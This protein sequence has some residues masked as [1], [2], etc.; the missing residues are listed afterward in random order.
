M[1]LLFAPSLP[2][3]TCLSSHGPALVAPPVC[4]GSPSRTLPAGGR[5]RFLKPR[6]SRWPRPV[7]GRRGWRAPPT[8]GV[9]LQQK[10][11]GPSGPSP[12]VPRSPGPSGRISREGVWQQAQGRARPTSGSCEEG[13]GARRTGG[14]PSTSRPSGHEAWSEGAAVPRGPLE[15]CVL[16]PGLHPTAQHRAA[17]VGLWEGAVSSRVRRR[18]GLSLI[19]SR[20]PPVPGCGRPAGPAAPAPAAGTNAA[21]SPQGWG[22]RRRPCCRPSGATSAPSSGAG[23]AASTSRRWPR[24]PWPP[25]RPRTRPCSGSGG[26]TTW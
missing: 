12:S 15:S 10:G 16:V 25:W 4:S 8:E 3:V 17:A 1:G 22:T 6:R 11:A 13:R 2:W 14:G 7:C 9:R 20:A 19:R 5:V 21:R 26:S 23:S 18:A 24:S